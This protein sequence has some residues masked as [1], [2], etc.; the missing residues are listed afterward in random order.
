VEVPAAAEQV[1]LPAGTDA[2]LVEREVVAGGLGDRRLAFAAGARA[3]QARAGR[4]SVR[5][6][7]VRPAVG[8]APCLP[9]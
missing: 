2:G 1:D 9:A 7:G 5:L 6:L 8:G 4:L 3:G